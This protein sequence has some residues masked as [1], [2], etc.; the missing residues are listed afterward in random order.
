MPDRVVEEISKGVEIS[1]IGIGSGNKT[2]GQV[3]LLQDILGFQ[4]TT[5]PKHSKRHVDV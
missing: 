4:K 2:D 3:V 1:I 5:T